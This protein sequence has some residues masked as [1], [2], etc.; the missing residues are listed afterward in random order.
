[1]TPLPDFLSHYYEAGVASLVE[2]I[3]QAG[4]DL[5]VASELSFITIR[6]DKS[7]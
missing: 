1:M 2:A 7:P 6:G 4:E 5:S 3:G